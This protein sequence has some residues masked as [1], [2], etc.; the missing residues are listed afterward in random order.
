MLWV[1]L[2]LQLTNWQMPKCEAGHVPPK[3]TSVQIEKVYIRGAKLRI[4]NVYIGS[5]AELIGTKHWISR[6]TAD[7]LIDARQCGYYTV[8]NGLII[9]THSGIAGSL[10]NNNFYFI[11]ESVNYDQLVNDSKPI[12]DF[13]VSNPSKR[14]TLFGEWAFLNDLWSSNFWHWMTEG[15]SKIYILE[16]LGYDGGYIVP[17]G[18]GYILESLR[19]LGIPTHRIRT[20]NSG[21]SVVERLIIADRFQ[22]QFTYPN[23]PSVLHGLRDRF[24]GSIGA[25]STNDYPDRRIY[26]ARDHNRKIVNEEDFKSLISQKDIHNRFVMEK[27]SLQEQINIVRNCDLLIS[28]H[29]AGMT[30]TMFM[31][32]KSVLIEMFA[33]TY[34]NPCMCAVAKHLR[35]RYH[36]VPSPVVNPFAKYQYGGDIFANLQAIDQIFASLET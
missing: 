28:P 17:S 10:D 15:L 21:F 7:R 33:P 6:F 11:T 20:L 8:K 1:G 34:I 32:P 31:P 2:S 35:Q 27:Y 12:V 22:G 30:L 5:A 3:R 19:L 36:M 18:P 24:F 14:E 25:Q 16:H 23:F 9:G 26:L 4:D 13:L 29:G